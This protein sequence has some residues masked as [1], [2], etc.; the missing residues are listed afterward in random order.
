M[1]GLILFYI[2]KAAMAG[3]LNLCIPQTDLIEYK[4]L[5]SHYR[6]KYL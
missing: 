5:T 4:T 1:D 6:P 2:L 3:S